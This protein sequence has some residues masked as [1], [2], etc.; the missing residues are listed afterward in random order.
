MNRYF[1]IMMFGLAIGL[2]ASEIA[3]AQVIVNSDG[4]HSVVHGNIVVNP[5][6]TH[7]TIHG[8]IVVNPNGSHSVIH[9]NILVNPD[10]SHTIFPECAEAKKRNHQKVARLNRRI[11]KPEKRAYLLT[12]LF[13]GSKNEAKVVQTTK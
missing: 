11:K 4:T 9:G 13:S 5:N 7:S 8:N 6:G 3:T 1:T 12:W 10:G 2:A